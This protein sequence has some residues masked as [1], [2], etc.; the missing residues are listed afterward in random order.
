ML[1]PVTVGSQE[2]RIG[3]AVWMKAV[4]WPCSCQSQWHQTLFGASELIYV[5]ERTQLFFLSVPL[6]Q[7][8]VLFALD[9]SGCTTQ[10]SLPEKWLVKGERCVEV[11]ISYGLCFWGFFFTSYYH[12]ATG[13]KLNSILSHI[14]WLLA[15]CH[16]NITSP[17]RHLFRLCSNSFCVISTLSCLWITACI[18]VWLIQAWCPIP[19]S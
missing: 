7:L 2:T 14:T 16:I 4:S 3:H 18:H 1:Q 12:Y 13:L 6:C 8:N 19:S 9:T 17:L 10:V 5:K 15:E 11:K